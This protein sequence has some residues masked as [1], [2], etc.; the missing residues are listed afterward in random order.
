MKAVM[1]SRGFTLLEM[2]IAIAIFALISTACYQLFKTV[3]QTREITRDIWSSTGEIQRGFLILH[4]DIYQTVS[5]PVRD[6]LGD[7]SDAM[8]S[9]AG[10]DITFTRSGWKNMNNAPRSELQR[11]HYFLD[12]GFLIREWWYML[13]LA[14]DAHSN[15]QVVLQGVN[16]LQFRFRDAENQWHEQW[17]P[18]SEKESEQ[19]VL[20]PEVIEVS[21]DHED[22]GVLTQIIPGPDYD[23]ESM[24]K[25]SSEGEEEKL[26]RRPKRPSGPRPGKGSPLGGFGGRSR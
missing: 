11:V 14:P 18:D 26:K 21:L 7:F 25:K 3:T 2:L 6:E 17:P 23:S 24:K 16:D 22:Y 5:R 1:S 9:D 12:D 19:R 15:Q 8:E 4:K 10:R 13:D 20:L